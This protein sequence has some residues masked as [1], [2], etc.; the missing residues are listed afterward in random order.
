MA[1]EELAG[2][3]GPWS[4]TPP[5]PSERANPSM[6]KRWLSLIGIGEGGADQLSASA[7]ALVR[8]AELVAGG[9]RHLALAKDLIQGETLAWPSPLSEALPSILERRGRPVVVLAS[10]DP[11]HF[12]IGARLAAA[13]PA[14]EIA[15]LPAPSAFSLAA[16]RLAWSLPDVTCLSLCGRPL[17]SLAPHLQP[18]RRLIVLSADETTPG[19][20]AAYL[21]ARGFGQSSV[22]LL[23]AL[24]GPREKRRETQAEDFAIAD[25]DRLNC[26]GISL[27]AAPGARVIPLSAGLADDCFESD[28]QMTKREMRA[29]TLSSLAPSAGELLWD[30]G[31][32]S[33]SVAIEWLLR[34]PA[35]RA[36]GIEPK[37]ERRR[38]AAGNAANLGVPRLELIAGSAPEAL[39]GLPQPDAIFV[40]GGATAPGALETAWEALRSGGRLVANGVTIE[41]ESLLAAR[42]GAL[43]GS[44][45]R[46]SVERSDQVGRFHAFR[47]AMAVTQWSAVKP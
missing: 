44:L 37:E 8:D 22:I 18:G 47:P 46:L 4:P 43:G 10:G 41:T 23:E 35:N 16:S 14:E 31:C 25:A 19:A 6:T 13:V 21:T 12:G 11:F 9:A 33:G 29:V 5:R 26:L 28:G 20:V 39:S 36:I 1:F 7:Q 24:D 15:C 3:A 42:F 45:V 27:V 2:G 32:G 17:E 34:H 38:M 40:G 30:I